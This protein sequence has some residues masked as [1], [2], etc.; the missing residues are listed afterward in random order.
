M[1]LIDIHAHNGAWP[2]TD[3]AKYDYLGET[4]KDFI[5]DLG[6][7]RVSL[8]FI[9]SVTALI[10]D[11]VKGNRLTYADAE[12]DKRLFAYTY[13]DPTRPR[14]ALREAEKYRDHPKFIGF[15]TRPDF[16][17]RL[18]TDPGYKGMIRLAAAWKKPVLLHCWPLE[19]ARA[20]ARAASRTRAV[21]IM[22]HACSADYK[23]AVPLIKPFPN[24]CVEPVTSRYYPGKVRYILRIVGKD[25]VLFGSDYGLV[26]RKRV[27]KYFREAKLSP[28]EARAVYYRNA[29]R[30]FGL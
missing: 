9:S 22:V 23:A 24:V 4:I 13:W 19:D 25:R 28:A 12:K 7:D 18:I 8:C 16:H 21:F 3:T 30:I 11:M 15:K 29:E 5:A 10:R 20:L 27:K 26:S 2:R 1:K 14:L 17:K 6:R